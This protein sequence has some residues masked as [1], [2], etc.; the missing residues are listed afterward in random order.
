MG[1][2]KY[3]LKFTLC[4]GLLVFLSHSLIA[5]LDS[6]VQQEIALDAFRSY[7][8]EI[9]SNTEEIDVYRDYP[10]MP[11]PSNEV[12]LGLQEELKQDSARYHFE[13]LHSSNW[14]NHHD[15]RKSITYFKR[16][17]LIYCLLAASVHWTP[18]RVNAI[19]EVYSLLTNKLKVNTTKEGFDRFIA[20]E[21]LIKR[22]Y[23]YILERIPW[24]ISGSEN[25]TIHQ[26]NITALA[27]CLNFICY[28][29]IYQRQLE[30]APMVQPDK[31]EKW[32]NCSK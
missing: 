16:N 20:R 21:L 30:E 13:K 4:T 23:I 1:R 17:D 8:V 25:S 15:Y 32:K 9:L 19:E 26:V 24:G 14:E 29:T 18:D 7:V 28:N 22:F 6:L 31:L 3:K 10:T 5:Q 27:K 2:I 12:L 11:N